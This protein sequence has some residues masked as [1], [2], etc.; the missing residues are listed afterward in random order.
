MSLEIGGRELRQGG[1]A[2]IVAEAACEHLGSLEIAR[3]MVEAAAEAG[4][5]VVKFQ[6]HLPGEMIPGS[7]R[8]WGG[9]MDEVLEQYNL[10]IEAQAKLM[11][12][13]REVG[14][15]YLCTPFSTRAGELLDDIGVEAFKVGSGEMT[16]HPMLRALAAFGKPMIVSTGMATLEEVDDAVEVLREVGAS[17]ALTNCTSA[18]PPDY[19][20]VSLGL[21]DRLHERYGVP[22]GHSDHTPDGWTAVGAAARGAAVIEKHFTLDRRL[23]GPDHHVSL[24]PHA[25][26]DMV[27]GVRKVERATGAR[28]AVT[29]DEQE[30]RAWARHSVV[31]TRGIPAGRMI[32][33]DMVTVKRPGTGIPAK[34]LHDVIG[35][36]TIQEIP[37]D[38]VLK[39]EHLERNDG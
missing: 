20:E 31:S 4:A 24:E 13:C 23:G 34:C 25:F 15:G 28:K 37:A 9:S 19:E 14:I 8:F 33:E 21:I 30:V 7:I 36:R 27:D 17:F 39:W 16:H 12:H 26:A 3:R 32:E 38:T 2:L 10:D 6:L 22:V 5:D 11:E 35:S 18:Y 29:E 1:P